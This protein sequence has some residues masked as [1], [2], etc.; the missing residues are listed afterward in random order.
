MGFSSDDGVLVGADEQ[1]S[2][3]VAVPYVCDGQAV[4]LAGFGRVA[5]D[6]ALSVV[7]RACAGSGK[8]WLLT[9]R[10]I[11]LLLAGVAPRYILAITFTKKAAQEMRDRVAGL[12]REMADAR[13]DEVVDL[14][15][16]RGVARGDALALVPRAQALY[17]EVLGS[18]QELPIYTFDAWF[19]RLLRAAPLG[20]G[21][22]RDAQLL[23]DA[24][25]L[26]MQ[27]WQGFFDEIKSDSGVESVLL[28]HYLGM[29]R[30]LGRL[31]AEKMLSAALYE[32]N[33]FEQ[34]LLG[35]S[36]G[37]DLV[38]AAQSVG[39]GWQEEARLALSA[40]RD[41]LRMQSQVD[42]DL[43]VAGV[44]ASVMQALLDSDAL[45]VM[46]RALDLGDEKKQA[47]ADCFEQ[48]IEAARAG[49]VVKFWRGIEPFVA[50]STGQLNG[51]LF[52]LTKAQIEGMGQVQGLSKEV[53][54]EA[55]ASVNGLLLRRR[56]QLA[57]LAA[58]TVHVDALP[59]VFA[60][61]AHFRDLKRAANVLEFSDVSRYC[62]ELLSDPNTAAFMQMQLD[63]RYRHLLFDE[64]QDT[65][66]VQ[67]GIIHGWLSGYQG[68]EAKPKVFLVGDVKQSIYRFRAA[69][70]TLFGVAQKYLVQHFDARVLQ[71]QFTRRNSPA[72]VAWVNALF[73]RADSLLDDFV[74]HSTAQSAMV[75][76]VACLGLL[77]EPELVDL[78][79]GV[80]NA[81]GGHEEAMPRDWLRAPAQV[82]EA[83]PHD[84]EGAQ[85]VR[86]IESLVGHYPV[87]DEA[88][89]GYR[90]AVYS[91]VMV[92]VYGRTHLVSYERLLREAHIPFESSRRGG[93]LNTLEALD[94]MALL[95]W[96][97]RP[98]DD[99]ALVQ[100]LRAPM[101][102]VSDAMLVQLVQ[103]KRAALSAVEGGM[104]A[105]VSY[106]QLLLDWLG[107]VDRAEDLIANVARWT[108]VVALLGEWL[109]VAQWMPP[110][111][112]LDRIYAQGKVYEAYA[113]VVPHWL[114]AQVQ[115]N[116]R[117]FLQLA[118]NVNSGRYPS[119][120]GLLGA[121]RRWQERAAEGLSEG[122]PVGMH[123]AVQILTVHA[124]KG[125]EAPIVLLID[126]KTSTR[127]SSG[128][129]WFVQRSQ[130]G[131][132]SHVSWL[133]SKATRGAWRF[134]ALDEEAR[135]LAMEHHNKCYVAMTR[136]RQ[137]LVVS[138]PVSLLAHRGEDGVLQ[139]TELKGDKSGLFEA[140]HAEC[141]QVSGRL[142]ADV[143]QW[144]EV[145]TQCWKADAVGVDPM[146]RILPEV[147]SLDVGVAAGLVV[148]GSVQDVLRVQE[149][150]PNVAG[151]A[152][153]HQA[154]AV[155]AAG[156]EDSVLREVCVNGVAL[157][158][159]DVA[160][161]VVSEGVSIGAEPMLSHAQQRAIDMG[162][163]LHLALEYA[164]D[165]HVACSI[166]VDWL[167]VHGRLEAEDAALVLLWVETL[168]EHPD[169]RDWFD[170]SL[171]DEAH[172]EMALMDERG[173]LKRVDRW[174]RRGDQ[175]TVLDYKS[176]WQEGQLRAYHEQVG[177]YV[178]L[179]SL[180]FP[181]CAVRGV[182]VRIDGVLSWCDGL[183]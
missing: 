20:S 139:G 146:G 13:V 71:T 170:A 61:L 80:L 47:R 48:A 88:L 181:N 22:A 62:F 11:R 151:V 4:D 104:Q 131:V 162:V 6:P 129:H 43:G 169:V 117:G 14:L 16:M 75:G 72:V 2:D 85:L 180:V 73:G 54:D 119:L 178:R 12:L 55:V 163:A 122:E 87:W 39:R 68:D 90:P 31:G 115:A 113:R 159:L 25:D 17:D 34:W 89:E 81:V 138:A 153:W 147:R 132:P 105:Q 173:G 109:A 86:A 149:V 160:G 18:G 130:A 172:N 32:G 1:K 98:D 137:L 152:L 175:I 134:S 120:R 66:P 150:F 96:L 118:L 142:S 52:K 36:E 23:V 183:V 179:L 29:V 59:C 171:W 3:G 127:D 128:G 38:E 58:Y 27:A 101:F 46:A 126:L 56:A 125:L 33:T 154:D 167:Q 164:S 135:L 91:D 106:W 15:M 28:G 83:S 143:S 19:F 156:R 121:L 74:T 78:D 174:V 155:R 69:D 35:L 107:Q 10:M 111:D 9:S 26:R 7:V 92:L 140:L 37:C 79:D 93:L 40:L 103:I 51:M 148:G 8:T 76:H 65:N 114:N 182:L 176:A 123:N 161:V 158:V 124:S 110:H 94:L 77:E 108:A 45:S 49:D 67:W 5:L 30:Q 64:F 24:D 144:S 116:L 42:V 168:F 100:V 63:A 70:A 166:T 102:D 41:E 82:Q 50:A 145:L 84:L 165:E 112:V 136:A 95:R 53:Y 44:D 99:W 21:V 97:L 157:D 60:L 177:E 57:D 141:V 133:G